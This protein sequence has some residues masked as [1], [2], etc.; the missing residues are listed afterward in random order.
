[1]PA[2]ATARVSASAGGTCNNVD[3]CDRKDSD[4][5]D[6]DGIMTIKYISSSVSSFPCR[7]STFGDCQTPPPLAA[8][9]SGKPVLARQGCQSSRCSLERGHLT[10]GHALGGL[11]FWTAN[12]QLPHR[13]RILLSKYMYLYMHMYIHK[14]MYVYTH[15]LSHTHIYI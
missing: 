3:T 15:T 14:Y 6:N 5:H 2:C 11:N 13:Q 1:M 4:R 10:R 9:Q 7:T 8:P 12:L